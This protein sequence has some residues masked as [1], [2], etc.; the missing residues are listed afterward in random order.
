M[1]IC[2]ALYVLVSVIVGCGLKEGGI[3]IMYF[4]NC[5]K[6]DFYKAFHSKFLLLH[7]LIPIIGVI[8]F[9]SYYAVSSWREVSK[10]TGYFEVCAGAF[11]LLAAIAVSLFCEEEKDAGNFNSMMCVPCSKINIHLS[12]LIMMWI[13]GAV[14]SLIAIGGFGLVF[15]SMGNL[16]FSMMF[17]IKMAL[18]MIIL[19]LPVYVIQYIVSFSL[20]KGASLSLG[21]VGSLL[22]LLMCTGLGDGIWFLIPYA[23]GIRMADYMSLNFLGGEFYSAVTSEAVQ[24]LVWIFVI[25][26]ILASMFLLWS[27]M[28]QGRK[29]EE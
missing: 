20:G 6:A 3:I 9:N 15:I 19:N 5:I 7:I 8:L 11:P 17:Y 23:Y 14:A 16:R 4:I 29:A 10:V 27:R 26:F 28:W 2:R 13:F 25:S 18:M 24:G 12:K 22:S 1:I 21:T